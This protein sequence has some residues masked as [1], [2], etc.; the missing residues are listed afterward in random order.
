MRVDFERQYE[1][2]RADLDQLL[3]CEIRRAREAGHG[4]DPKRSL[5]SALLASDHDFSD[6]YIRDQI[7]SVLAGGVTTAANGMS[8]A[9]YWVYHRPDVADRLKAELAALPS[10]ATA[11]EIG[12]LPYLTAV[13]LEALRVPTVTPT[14][15][16]R[17]VNSSFTEGEYEFPEGTEVIVAIQP[18]H[19]DESTYPDHAEFRPERFLEESPSGME[20]MPFGIGSHFCVGAQLAELEMKLTVAEALRLPGFGLLGADMELIPRSHGVNLTTPHSIKAFCRPTEQVAPPR[21]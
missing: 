16:A 6:E 11:L 9:L 1:R 13:C 17:R 7:V 10:N 21:D 4:E 8:M 14:G 2:D 19:H 3:L 18:A 20:Y 12:A 5:L 15:D